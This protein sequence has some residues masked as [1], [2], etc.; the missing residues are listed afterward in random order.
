MTTTRKVN[1]TNMG[2]ITDTIMTMA[3]ITR[4][5]D[6]TSMAITTITTVREVI[7]INITM[8]KTIT[9][10]K[11]IMDMKNTTTT[12]TAMARKEVTMATRNG[13]SIMATESIDLMLDASGKRACPPSE[14]TWSLTPMNTIKPKQVT[15]AFPTSWRRIRHLMEGGTLEKGRGDGKGV[16]SSWTGV[17]EEE[18]GNG[19]RRGPP[20][21]SL[22]GRNKTAE[23]AT[24]TRREE[25]SAGSERVALTAQGAGALTL[26]A[27]IYVGLRVYVTITNVY[28]RRLHCEALCLRNAINLV[29]GARKFWLQKLA[30]PAAGTPARP[31]PAGNDDA[32]LI[33]VQNLAHLSLR[34][35]TAYIEL[36]SVLLTGSQLPSNTMEFPKI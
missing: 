3:V 34:I 6:I 21:L 23:A 10:I 36:D 26:I 9:A 15:Y 12:T 33:N 24:F 1:I 11:D 8:M 31:R 14:S 18:W 13:V 30:E 19:M 7:T 5:E 28:T 20:E 16:N 4:K 17:M 25:Q 2:N 29:L 32:A 27:G 22:T 35:R